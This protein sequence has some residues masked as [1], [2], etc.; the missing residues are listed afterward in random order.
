MGSNSANLLRIESLDAQ[1]LEQLSGKSILV[2]PEG[3]VVIEQIHELPFQQHMKQG[4]HMTWTEDSLMEKARELEA[5]KREPFGTFLKPELTCPLC[6]G[7]LRDGVHI[8]CCGA[9]FCDSCIRNYLSHQ[10]STTGSMTC[11]SCK[12]KTDLDRVTVDKP[13]R[14]LVEQH[15]RT[16]MSYLRA[17]EKSNDRS[18]I[19]DTFAAT[20]ASILD[21]SSPQL[22]LNADELSQLRSNPTFL[23]NDD[24]LMEVRDTTQTRGFEF[25]QQNA[26]ILDL[27]QALLN[28]VLFGSHKDAR[29]DDLTGITPSLKSKSRD[30]D[31]IPTKEYQISPLESLNP[32]DRVTLERDI[33]YEN[34]RDKRRSERSRSPESRSSHRSK[35]YRSKSRDRAEGS[36]RRR[37]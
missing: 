15:L 30:R 21:N 6:Y 28:Y 29:H 10:V 1:K 20:S 5:S 27:D 14:A 24:S 2:T 16:I 23:L 12:R 18:K 17:Q 8:S 37:W 11:P 33:Y 9:S 36:G 34:G 13:R 4:G 35:R 26:T 25:E 19:H 7:L 22:R 32:L 31:L 3:N